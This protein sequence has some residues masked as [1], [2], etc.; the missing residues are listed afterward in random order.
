ML[1]F[2]EN[3]VTIKVF[4]ALSAAAVFWNADRVFRK[5]K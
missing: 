5:S 3:P 1:D 4:A 2:L